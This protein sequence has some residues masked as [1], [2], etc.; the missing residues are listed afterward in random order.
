MVL[1][2]IN[3]V[4]EKNEKLSSFYYSYS[5]RFNEI[6]ESQGEEENKKATSKTLLITFQ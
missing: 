6:P 4:E 3:I 5:F 1:V 2:S